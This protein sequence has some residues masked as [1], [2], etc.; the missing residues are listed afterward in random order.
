MAILIFIG[1]IALVAFLSWVSRKL[2]HNMV[3]DYKYML[4]EAEPNQKKQ[5]LEDKI[6]TT[7]GGNEVVDSMVNI[8]MLTDNRE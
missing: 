1:F 3:D 2:T 5:S 8:S 4:S 6:G 7:M